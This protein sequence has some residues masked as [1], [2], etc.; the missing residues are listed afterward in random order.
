MFEFFAVT[1]PLALIILLIY[2]LVTQQM[3]LIAQK[4]L[5]SYHLSGT[6]NLIEKTFLLGNVSIVNVLGS[7]PS[8]VVTLINF[9]ISLGLILFLTKI[10]KNK[11]IVIFTFFLAII[12]LT[13][14]LFFTL[15]PSEFPYSAADFSE[16]Y[17][18]AEVSMWLF[19]PF[20][21][22]M[23][24]LP[25]PDSLLIKMPLIIFTFL[26]SVIFGTLRYAMFL[27]I[28][29]EFS[30]IYMAVL[31]FAFGP[32]IDFFYIVG[33]YCFYTNRLAKKLKGT[34]EVWKWSY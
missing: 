32:L 27:F 17:I 23:A 7:Y 20:V 25:L 22:G 24:F 34:E 14:A 2:P 18:K 16:L 11:N 33:I 31:F 5:S 13:S 19:I 12:N 3:S 4:I 15:S 28:I 26:Y 10:K 1:I 30:V 29:S 9:L 8:P 6:P 21:L